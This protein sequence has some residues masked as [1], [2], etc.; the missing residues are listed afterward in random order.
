MSDLTKSDGTDSAKATE[1]LRQLGETVKEQFAANARLLSFAEYL[2][3]VQANPRRHLRNSA[4]Y[5]RDMFD[6]YGTEKVRH[7]TGEVRRFMNENLHRVRK[8]RGAMPPLVTTGRAYDLRAVYDRLNA[9]FFG[10]RLFY[11]ALDPGACHF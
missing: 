8:A 10:G 4:H 6:Y 7:P 9:S 3:L 1:R 2:A 11:D 5:L